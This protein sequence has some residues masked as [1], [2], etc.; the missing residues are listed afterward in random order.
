MALRQGRRCRGQGGDFPG[1]SDRP[2]EL[3][4]VV[5]IRI[6]IISVRR[7]LR[8]GHL[9]TRI[10]ETI[11]Q[12][13]VRCRDQVMGDDLV[14]H[15]NCH[16]VEGQDDQGGRPGDA[17]GMLAMLALRLH[18]SIILYPVPRTV[19]MRALLR[20]NFARSRPMWTSMVFDPTASASLSHTCTAMLW[21][22]R[23]FG[24]LR[25]R[26]STSADSMA[27]RASGSP[28]SVA[29]RV[30]GSKQRV[31]HA[32]TG[33]IASGGRRCNACTASNELG[34]VKGLDEIIVRALV[35]AGDP[36]GRGVAGGEH[37]NGRSIPARPRFRHDFDSRTFGHAPIEHGHVV[38]IGAQVA[39]RRCS[40][41]HRVDD[42]S[43][44]T[45]PTFEDRPQ[46]GIVLCHQ[47]P[48]RSGELT[49]DMGFRLGR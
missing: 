20:S 24:L 15:D 21:R 1:G 32:S 37:E 16:D 6:V 19:S 49:C 40:V 17:Q 41:R 23:T 8:C 44:L 34:K 26:S 47:N 42:I 27:V 14:E 11:H 48:H 5:D 45:Q 3:R 12:A 4:G 9:L 29:S 43:V 7:P 36:I 31:P 38:L 39:Q 35:E 10:V 18:F 2:Q 13:I 33:P 22:V 30:A 25:R 28:A 46:C